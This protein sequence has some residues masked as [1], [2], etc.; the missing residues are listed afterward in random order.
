MSLAAFLPAPPVLSSYSATR[1]RP[2]FAIPVTAATNNSPET[3]RQQVTAAAHTVVVKVG[4]RVLTQEDGTLDYKRIEQLAEEI[5]AISS[6]GRRVVLVSSGAVGAG[7]SLLGLKARPTDLAKLQAVAA[8]GQTHLIQTYDSTFAKHGRR[9]AQV[10][11]TVEDVDDRIRY[12]NVRNTLHSLLDF[13]AVP[14]INENDTVSVDE[15]KTTFGDNDRLAAMVTN[16]LRAP[17]LIVLSDIDGLYDGDPALSQSKLVSTVEQI[18]EHVL[19]FV[20]DRKTGLSKGGMASKLEAARMVT[21]SGENMIIASGRK[22][23]VLTRIM[24]GDAVGT[25]FLGQGKGISPFKRWLGFSAQV[26]GRIQLD[27]GARRA[28]LEK[29]KS[30]LAAG[31]TGTQ[32]EFQKGDVVALCDAEGHVI[33]RG[34]TNYSSADLERIKGIKSEKIS[35]VL[36]RRPYEEVIHRDNLAIVKK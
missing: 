28:I 11:L 27:D 7:I 36:G 33:A 30:L 10:L 16:L 2:H 4:T 25:L 12:L 17:L 26:K 31:I 32:G 29:G 6:G 34:L 18:D 5:H 1:R 8:V 35:Q 23:D 14:I 3:H 24:G 9:A 22:T 15:L 19:A 21:T 13:G 20:R